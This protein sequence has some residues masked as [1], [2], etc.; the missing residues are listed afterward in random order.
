MNAFQR[1]L[2]QSEGK[3][4]EE[5]LKGPAAV[6]RGIREARRVYAW[7]AS[8]AR[9]TPITKVMA[10][11]FTNGSNVTARIN[12]FGRLEFPNE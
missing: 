2:I 6:R 7:D 5:T 8:L 3:W 4:P 9:Y 1:R 11:C 12:R 10:R